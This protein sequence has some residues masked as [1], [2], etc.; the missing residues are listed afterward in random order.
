LFW[1]GKASAVNPYMT[2]PQNIFCRVED[3]SMDAVKAITFDFGGTLANGELDKENYKRALMDYIFRL[4]YS[5]G[6]AKLI[7]A[8]VAM[9]GRLKKAREKNRELR[10]E[11]L[12]RGLL[13]DLGLHPAQE[14]LDYIEQ[15]Y[16][17]FFRI[18]LIPGIRE[19]LMDLSK[20]YNLAII[21]N[22]ISNASRLVLQKFDLEQYFDYIVLSRDLG[23]R[24]PDSEIFNFALVNLG[25]ISSEVVHVGDSLE[26]DIQ[27]AR[28]VGMKTVL[29]KGVNEITNIHPDFIISKVTELSSLF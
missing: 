10:F 8:R 22:V 11:E 13:F 15:L 5:G 23:I 19:M 12:Y 2:G 27:G 7:K 16:Y 20:R 24:K 17:R 26:D 18:D 28:N 29:I 21:S 4:G 9:L 3:G 14:R 6:R 1:V 25:V